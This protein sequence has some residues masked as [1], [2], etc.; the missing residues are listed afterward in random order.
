MFVLT[1][2]CAYFSRKLI[3][4]IVP[5]QLWL[6]ILCTYDKMFATHPTFTFGV[7]NVKGNEAQ[8]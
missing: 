6:K 2:A 5:K 8:R 7:I 3:F 1:V 4:L